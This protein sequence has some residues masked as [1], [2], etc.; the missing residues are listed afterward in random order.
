MLRAF[1]EYIELLCDFY[2]LIENVIKHIQNYILNKIILILY[3]FLGVIFIPVYILGIPIFLHFGIKKLYYVKF[4]PE[5]KNKYDNKIIIFFVISGEIIL[6]LVFCFSLM[7]VQY[8]YLVLFLPMFFI[9]L[10]IR[11]IIY[12]MPISTT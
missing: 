8:I 5:I 2:K 1:C 7:I 10:I 11:N 9:I 3:I 6:S 4:I 12:R